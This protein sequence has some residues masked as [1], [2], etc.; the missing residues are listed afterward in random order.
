MKVGTR[1]LGRSRRGVGLRRVLAVILPTLAVILAL[2][3]PAGANANYGSSGTFWSF[4]GQCSNWAHSWTSWT[5]VTT[6]QP[7][8]AM[9]NLSGYTAAMQNSCWFPA[10]PSGGLDLHNR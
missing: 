6:C 1:Q 7:P 10:E 4:N 9:V 5:Q 8:R 3:A 2:A